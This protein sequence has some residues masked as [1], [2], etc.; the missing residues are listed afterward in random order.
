VTDGFTG[1]V[2]LKLMEDM[3]AFMV[4]LTL[5]ELGKHGVQAP[6]QALASIKQA[7]DYSE[8]GGAPLL[9]VDGI[10][11]IGHGRSDEYAVANALALAARALDA[12]VNADIVAGL[13][14]SGG[15]AGA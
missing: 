15:G 6:P 13:A 10:V 11:I 12:G 4:K 7:I 5:S 14:K 2:V 8:Y 3:A 9:G 1:N